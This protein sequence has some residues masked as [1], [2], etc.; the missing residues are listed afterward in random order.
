MR[1]QLEDGSILSLG[2]RSELIVR[3]HN[4]RTQVSSIELG[5]G[6]VRAQV[7]KLSRP[8][9]KFEIRTNTAICGVLGTDE[10]IEA[11]TPFSTLVV[12]MSDPNSRSQVEVRNSDARVVGTVVLN[13]GQA[14]TVDQGKPPTGAR[15]ASG[16]EVNR[17]QQD[18]ATGDQPMA[19]AI[20]Q[21]TSGTVTPGDTPTAQI[22][23]GAQLTLDGRLSTSGASSFSSFL[24][25]IPKRNLR[26]NEPLW[27]V[28]T[29]NWTP[30]SY[31]GTL[32]VTTVQNKTATTRFTIVVTASLAGRA[33]P[34]EAIQ[35]LARAYE[36]LQ[37]SQF[38]S[39]FDQQSYS[40]Y[41]ALEQTINQSFANIA[42]NRVLVRKA[43]GTISGDTAV[44]QVE[45]EIRFLPKTSALPQSG[46][47][48]MGASASAP[49]RLVAMSSGVR[50]AATA[51][52]SGNVGAVATFVTLSDLNTPMR[53][54]VNTGTGMTY[55]FKDLPPGKYML[56][57]SRNG[58][59]FSPLSRT[60]DLTEAGLTG[61]D[62]TATALTQVVRETVTVHMRYVPN[63]SWHF[64]N[65]SGPIGSAGLVGVP[66]V[67]NPDQGSGGG[68]GG[69]GDVAV[70]DFKVTATP[71]NLPPIAR[72]GA[73]TPVTVTIEP[74]NG[75]KGTVNITWTTGLG[76]SVAPASQ[77]V[78][79][80]TGAV[81]QTF[82]V[83]AGAGAQ[84]GDSAVSFT[85]ESGN[86]KKQG[87]NTLTV[88]ALTLS[89]IGPAVQ[90]FAGGSTAQLQIKVDT[91]PTI[92]TPITVSASGPGITSSTAT[93][94]G[95]GTASLT[96]TCS[97]PD[98]G[99]TTVTVTASGT[100]IP[101]ATLAVPVTRDAPFTISGGGTVTFVA[102][103]NGSVS[104][105]VTLATGFTGQVAVT[106]P[107]IA[108]LTFS[109]LSVTRTSS[110]AAS[111]SVTGAAPFTGSGTFT[112]TA[113]SYS[114]LN[115]VNFNVT[116]VPAISLS[117]G[118]PS[119]ALV[120]G[121]APQTISVTLTRTNYTGAV[122]LSVTGLPTGVTA[123]STDP[124]TGNT[125][126]IVL[127]ASAQATLATNQ[128]ITVKASGSGVSDAP[129]TFSLTV[130]AA[131]AISLSLGSSSVTLTAG[132]GPQTVNLTITRTNYAGAVTLGVSG[133]PS[134]V[135][136][137]NTDPATGNT[138]SIVLQA[139]AVASL[140]G[141]QTITVT[142]SGSGVS[143][144]SAT[145]SLTVL[146][147]PA[148]S[149][150]LGNSSVTLTAGGGPQTVT[151]TITR[152]N[153]AG[154][155]T[156]SVSGLAT[157]VTAITTSPG[158]GNSGSIVLQ[159]SAV[160]TAAFNQTITVAASGSGV[161]SA[162]ATINLTVTPAGGPSISLSLGMSSVTLA[163]GGGS[164]TVGV[165][166]TRTNYTGALTLSVTGLPTGVT[167]AS[168][169][170]G[171]GNTGSIVLQALA[172]ATPVSNQ[173][174]T[175]TASGSG[176]GAASAGIGLTVTPAGVA[177]IS[178]S[179][180]TSSV[181]LAVGGPSQT[182][183]VTVTRTNY[184]GALTLSVSGLPTGVTA[185]ITSPGTGNTG[186]IVLQA[187]AGAT[188]ASNQPIAITA[189]GSGVS[190]ASATCSLTVAGAPAIS[191]S[192]GSS[193]V[194]LTAG[195]ASQTVSV[196]V[197]RTN[198]TGAVTLSVTGLPTGVTAT[199][200]DPGTGNTGSI[201]LQALAGATLVSNQP[202]TITASG[203]GVS[204]APATCSLTV[205]AAPAISLSLDTPSATLEAGGA[206]QTIS[207]ALT[208]TN[209]TGAVTLS[210]TGLPTGVTATSTDPGTG[211]TGSIV[212]QA[213]AEATLATD[214]TITVKASGSGVSAASATFS[215]TVAA[216]PAISLSLSSSSV[217]L[218]AGGGPQTVTV[219]ITRTN[220]AGAVTLSVSGLATGVSAVS[221]S[222]GAGNSGSIVLQA[223]AVATPA[224]NQ[225]IT[226]AASGSGVSAASATINLT[227]N[228]APP[229]P[230]PPANSI[231][232]FSGGG[233]SG[234]PGTQLPNPL[235]VLVSGAASAPVAGVTV[236]FAVSPTGAATLSSPTATTGAD[237][238]A[239]VTVTLG[240]TPGSVTVTA[241]VTG[242]SG[243]AT[244]TLTALPP[245]ITIV[246]GDEQGATVGHALAN[247][248]VVKVADA[249][250][251]PV[252]NVPVSF[253]VT[254]GTA[255]LSAASV[256]T[257]TNGQA[258]VT[259]TL[260]TTAG[261]VTVTATASGIATPVTFHL[262][263]LPGPATTLTAVSGTPQSGTVGQA[264]ANPLV[265]KATDSYGNPVPS[266]A[267][268]FQVTAGTATLSAASVNTGTDGQAQVTVTL[269]TA[270]GDVTVRAYIYDVAAVSFSLAALPGPATAITV[271]SG[272]PQSGTVG[273]ALTNPLVVK[274]ADSYGNPVSNV[275]VTF[276]APTGLTL[277]ATSVTT[278]ANGQAQVNVT[279]LPSLAGTYAVTAS[280]SGVTTPATFSL[281]AVA[282]SSA[283]IT[284]VS[285]S[286]QSGTVGAPLTAPL[287]VKVTD[288]SGNPVSN[289]TVTF[290]APT[291]LTLSATSATTGTNG[292]AQVNVTALP[293]LAGTYTV[294]A[295][296]S[297]VTTP[298]T[299]SLSAV[300]GGPAAIA[301]V[302]GSPQSGAVGAPLTPPLVVKVTDSSSNPVSNVTVTFSA[303]TGLT[304]SATSATTGADGQ[305]QVN[306]TG[307][308]SL[309][310][311]YT[312]T[313]SV[314]G[315]TT[316]ATFSLTAL[317]G[318]PAKL[319]VVSGT[320]QSG[321][322]GQVLAS[323]LVVKLTDASDNPIANVAIAFAVTAGG[324]ALGATSVTTAA[325][326]QA[327]TTWTLGSVGTNTVA[328]SVPSAPS[329]PA[330]TFTATAVLLSGVVSVGSGQAPPG[331][332][333][334]V[335]V[336]I[337]FTNLTAD[338]VSFS[339][340]V[341]PVGS[342]PALTGTGNF[343]FTPSGGI[344]NPTL[345]DT[346]ARPDTI[347]LSFL[348]VSP[349]LTG[350]M[351]LGQLRIKVP[352]A[353][354]AVQTYTIHVTGGSA[355]LG[356]ATSIPVQSG[357]DGTL[358]V[359]PSA[360]PTGGGMVSAGSVS[361]APGTTVP[362][363]ITVSLSGAAAETLSFSFT[364]VPGASGLPMT[365]TLSFVATGAP[366][367]G[368]INASTPSLISVAWL[369][370]LI[371]PPLSGSVTVGN[372]L[373]PIPSTGVAAGQ[374]Y[375]LRITGSSAT[376]SGA[377]LSMTPG[378]DATLAISAP[379]PDL[380][381]MSRSARAELDIPADELTYTPSFPREGDT[382]K[383]RVRVRNRGRN[384]ARGAELA[385]LA[386]DRVMASE[387]V[388][389]SAGRTVT[390]EL[391][392]KAEAAAARDLRFAL[393]TA[394]QP[395]SGQPDGNP[396]AVTLRLR[397]FAVEPRGGLSSVRR[398]RFTVDVRN[399][400]CAGLRLL[401]G[402]Q[403]SCGGSA[404]IEFSAFI[405]DSGRIVVQAFANDGGLIDL[406]VQPLA[407][408]AAAPSAG[409]LPQGMLESGR[410]YAIKARNRYALV[411]IA[412]IA[413]SVNPRLVADERRRNDNRRRDGRVIDEDPSQGIR[414][415]RTLDRVLDSARISIQIEYLVQEDG[416]VNFQ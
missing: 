196:T 111:F 385:L 97:G 241:T 142:A 344:P 12:N 16:S 8:D 296:V 305:A 332:Y 15:Q 309:A 282:G 415:S 250:A 110:G 359:N 243:T 57:P 33:A 93:V 287:V 314:S 168:T 124:G 376:S 114:V 360:P 340:M 388:D 121:G 235:V 160:A 266:V 117:L 89:Q 32:T 209:Y 39:C 148:I 22:E 351:V 61:V 82:T 313:A 51:S 262:T 394:G 7:V 178:L 152:T 91:A 375:T 386:Q 245:T 272:T 170:P 357:A 146:P 372:V 406:G 264:L 165:T 293:S 377:S 138:G 116:P 172:E 327:Q 311:T 411:R 10:Y 317:P 285:G 70:A 395:G 29:A 161:S 40:G 354:T 236:N 280:V 404:D 365:T 53:L 86:I 397:N 78:T 366:T 413:S 221:T 269:G 414:D 216:A 255:T 18:T 303:P 343:S 374:T 342:A 387:R 147:A 219:T 253:Q 208:R 50:A 133:L 225:T 193:S 197:T 46:V 73:G 119:V 4:A 288:S 237:G 352:P 11:A 17:G 378:P 169:S 5:Y 277:S 201:V 80:T 389:I 58:F 391:A 83:S 218:T 202:I 74:L 220:Y 1:A 278:G 48:G 214:Q 298:A 289:V 244:F 153:Y 143:A 292:Q 64:D 336:N 135:S 140:V 263:A 370:P 122:T 94:N 99:A 246:S 162:S 120:A 129:A 104:F 393:R 211:N 63:A 181:T 194:T 139:S 383:F 261:T 380:Q 151:V 34:D 353:A 65:L 131:P 333:A 204:A 59:T 3:E 200:T 24:W 350:A 270:A 258:Q 185:A 257:G 324:G 44:Y 72:G 399:E 335:P 247:P 67:G 294:T 112:A 326:G 136:A 149:L 158:T 47:P 400:G 19:T 144:A 205:A 54:F 115:S 173:P 38:L 187:L 325:N 412:R 230:P 328:A 84:L 367:P 341:T 90:L 271:V 190:A 348:N 291:G 179:L 60:V 318:A 322:V 141:N 195:G 145:F 307:L 23:A 109:P 232:A 346:G 301:V 75:F 362:V 224:P 166:V 113:G 159:A 171:T 35:A 265:V 213:S 163:V 381:P 334:S 356:S 183:S 43:N 154:A 69:G 226:V 273:Q 123:N 9:S 98:T 132:G 167:A 229:P 306:V 361:G 312:V 36:S 259:V 315:V 182:V 203:S 369:S 125:G 210:V 28:P 217:T 256:N 358:T 252:A 382:V 364:I 128:T 279:G 384:D 155:V 192:L 242:V 371:S 31:E 198:Y 390:V 79:I 95:N 118:T 13:G 290:S 281:S 25:Q 231:Q 37:V 134:G 233:Q 41:A 184:T 308:P 355:N 20:L 30:G 283:A 330:V 403:T 49:P 68:G 27:V 249:A 274:V 62:F 228:A 321:T 96:L 156:L 42:E 102:G 260:G 130:S 26:S 407:S 267:I 286:P 66:G 186:S 126:S 349:P 176:V 276:S 339:V 410:T 398:E 234:A 206:S 189:S 6:Q 103:G 337:N 251:S 88:Y 338:G 212:L 21:L 323:P 227:V 300:A 223:S 239:S 180:G 310:G 331:A 254:V 329:I 127:Q 177:S 268:I 373:L 295:S 191:L 319:T 101:A 402:S 55:S 56:T 248:L 107:L 76:V 416:S 302:S 409:Y 222:P 137:T 297:G 77:A 81:S 188:L 174:I 92:T 401:T 164:Q 238:K 215:L 405:N 363:P 316:P 207:V 157:G 175:I 87:T 100:G 299:F 2:Q 45:F 150:S 320:P 275:T 105:D 408:V 368:T 379:A 85:A 240:P 14:T 284:V 108:G 199:S 347:S 345:T 304:L 52:I 392:W 71:Q 106:A 396:P